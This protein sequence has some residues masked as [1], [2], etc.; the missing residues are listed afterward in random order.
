MKKKKLIISDVTLRDGNHAV[1][2]SISKD[3]I[4]KYCLQIEKANIKIVEVGHGNE[5]TP[6]DL[7]TFRNL[8]TF[9]EI[10]RTFAIYGF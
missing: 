6:R 1:N 10:Q 9:N 7:A 8:Q 5:N 3:I 2:H 4:K